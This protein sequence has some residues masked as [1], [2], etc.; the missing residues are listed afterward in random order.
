M[1]ELVNTSDPNLATRSE[2]LQETL[3]RREKIR[4]ARKKAREEKAQLVR[5][6]VGWVIDNIF[7]EVEAAKLKLPPRLIGLLQRVRE[8]FLR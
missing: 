3:A 5:E 6:T 7:L 4:S 8:D 1:L 2:A